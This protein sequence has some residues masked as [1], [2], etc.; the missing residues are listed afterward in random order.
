MISWLAKKSKRQSNCKLTL[1]RSPRPAAP[2][3]MSV[4]QTIGFIGAGMMA[5]ALASGFISKG[6]IQAK[7]VYCHDPSTARQEVFRKMGANPCQSGKEV[8]LF[9]LHMSEHEHGV[10]AGCRPL[11]ADGQATASVDVDACTQSALGA[12]TPSSIAS[13]T[14]YH[15]AVW[16][17]S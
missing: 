8:R 6:V 15:T 13:W 7:Q 14:L 10:P 11:E 4:S 1:H 5:E 12:C 17:L 2:V 3:A 16:C 9:A